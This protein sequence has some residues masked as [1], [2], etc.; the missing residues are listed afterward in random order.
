MCFDELYR[1]IARVHYVDSE[2]WYADN[3]QLSFFYNISI[4]LNPG[5]LHPIFMRW[6]RLFKSPTAVYTDRCIRRV[7]PLVP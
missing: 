1:A 2:I 5:R 7:R 4:L 6:R 3:L